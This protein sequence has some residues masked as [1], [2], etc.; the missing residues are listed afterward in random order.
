MGGL[1]SETTKQ[2]LSVDIVCVHENMMN[3]TARSIQSKHA[4]L[5]TNYD[6]RYNSILHYI[7]S[8]RITYK[9]R[10]PIFNQDFFLLTEE[11]PCFEIDI[12]VDNTLNIKNLPKDFITDNKI[13][14]VTKTGLNISHF[15]LNIRTRYVI[16]CNPAVF[17]E[18]SRFVRD[19]GIIY[20][21][22]YMMNCELLSGIDDTGYFNCEFTWFNVTHVSYPKSVFIRGKVTGG[23]NI[24]VNTIEHIGNHLF[25]ELEG[26]CSGMKKLLVDDLQVDTDEYINIVDSPTMS[27]TR[28]DHVK[29]QIKDIKN[30]AC[31]LCF[32][33][34]IDMNN[35]AYV[36]KCCQSVVCKTCYLNFLGSRLPT[37]FTCRKINC[38]FVCIVDKLQDKE[39]LQ[40]NTLLLSQKLPEYHED[41]AENLVYVELYNDTYS[42]QPRTDKLRKKISNSIKWDNVIFIDSYKKH[43][44]S[45]YSLDYIKHVIRDNS[46]SG[47]KFYIKI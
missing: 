30:E 41:L 1:I 12:I 35:G 47:C 45:R 19:N 3:R 39:K 7:I 40:G 33:E 26:T 24:T 27:D 38:D 21:R 15:F 28:K 10:K 42:S 6:I 5:K 16:I 22:S 2:M 20:K 8:R 46:L 36:T 37:C 11:T 17:K 18:I 32:D 13:S 44:F 43:H 34:K 29:A 4:L 9:T 31:C 14:V 25:N 23:Y